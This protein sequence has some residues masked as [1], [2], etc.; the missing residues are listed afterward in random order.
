MDTAT[1]IDGFIGL[2]FKSYVLI[3]DLISG[4]EFKRLVSSY[5]QRTVT[6]E[7]QSLRSIIINLLPIISSTITKGKVFEVKLVDTIDFTRRKKLHFFYGLWVESYRY[8]KDLREKNE[9]SIQDLTVEYDKL[10]Y[11]EIKSRGSRTKQFTLLDELNA[12]RGMIEESKRLQIKLDNSINE[13]DEIVD[14]FRIEYEAKYGDRL[15]LEYKN[16]INRLIHSTDE[17]TAGNI[18]KHKSRSDN[19]LLPF[20]FGEIE[21]FH[22]TMRIF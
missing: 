20:D 10:E 22:D 19:H 1:F 4:Y 5:D 15:K 18:D 7:S 6:E 17:W 12:A 3:V 9:K 21:G 8:I 2:N 13:M 11:L 16:K 14:D